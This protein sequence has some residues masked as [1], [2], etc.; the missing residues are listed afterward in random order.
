MNICFV[1]T[2]PS[3]ICS[4]S[5]LKDFLLSGNLFTCSPLC[6]SSVPTRNV[7]NNVCTPNQD[8]ALC[9]LIA[10]TNIHSIAGYSQWN[11]SVYGFTYTN[12]CTSPL[13]PGITCNVNNSVASIDVDS[14]NIIGSIPM[15][16]GSLTTLTS[17]QLYNNFL[18]GR[19][20][21]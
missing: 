21:C 11:C 18:S 20:V 17:L 19:P 14:L 6:V 2:I 3:A 10:A 7:P 8:G 1:G 16:L 9:G 5:G 4:V 15:T 12:P 13:W